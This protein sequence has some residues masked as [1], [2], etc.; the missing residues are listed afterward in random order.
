M[1]RMKDTLAADELRARIEAMIVADWVS[2]AA[3]AFAIPV[4]PDELTRWLAGNPIKANLARFE[5]EIHAYLESR[6]AWLVEVNSADA[7]RRRELR[8]AKAQEVRELGA[9]LA[10]EPPRSAYGDMLQDAIAFGVYDLFL[11]SEEGEATNCWRCGA[12]ARKSVAATATVEAQIE[13]NLRNAGW[14]TWPEEV[15]RERMRAVMADGEYIIAVNIG[16]A[17][18]RRPDGT[19]YRAL[20]GAPINGGGI[21]EA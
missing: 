11:L 12:T 3:I 5:K 6:A 20:R 2:I 14:A 10:E 9:K 16:G 21:E 4:S 18:I 15:F 13:L 1:A 7:V 8:L 19:V 17:W